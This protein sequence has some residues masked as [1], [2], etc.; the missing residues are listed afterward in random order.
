M[1]EFTD[2]EHQLMLRL[3]KKSIE[4]GF[5]HG[6]PCPVDPKTIP[7]N[8]HA[9]VRSFVSISTKN[10][11]NLGCM[12]NL[13][14]RPMFVA[15]RNNAFNSAFGDNRF[16]PLTKY[17]INQQAFLKIHYLFEGTI[18]NNINKKRAL[19]LLKPCHSLIISYNG[20][21]TAMVSGMQEKWGKELFIDHT[22]EKSKTAI[23][24]ALPLEFYE[25]ELVNTTSSPEI[26]YSEIGAM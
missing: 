22:L 21:R 14:Q 19:E 8:L 4:H 7:T 6:A 26:K 18:Y 10:G 3:A 20:S 24:Q 5:K 11:E 15:V 2:E 1:I 13:D 23:K 17:N 12:G 9:V 16:S 25:V